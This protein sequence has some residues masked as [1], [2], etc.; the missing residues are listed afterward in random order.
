MYPEKTFMRILSFS[1]VEILPS[2]L[3]K[4]KTQTIRSAWKEGINEKG[5]LDDILKPPRF[6]VG[7]K[8]Q[9][10]WKQRSKH[11]LFCGTCGYPLGNCI[12]DPKISRKIY[13][14]K[15]LGEVEITETFK[16]E[17]EKDKLYWI[18]IKGFYQQMDFINKLTKMDGFKSADQMFE[19]FDNKYDLSKPKEFWVYRWKWL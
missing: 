12:C 10:M 19:W 8:V 18:K 9:L 5:Q 15:R 16:I 7:E 4:S 6:K 11:N 14:N 1:V 3:D 2:L 13:F 17:M